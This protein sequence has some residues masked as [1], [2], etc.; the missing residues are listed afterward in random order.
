MCTSERTASTSNPI[1]AIWASRLGRVCSR[2]TYKPFASRCRAFAWRIAYVR[3]DFIVPGRPDTSTTWPTGKPPPR[4]SS[5]PSM[6]VGI[7]F[8]PMELPPASFGQR[9]ATRPSEPVEFPVK[10][11]IEP[12]PEH[13]GQGEPPNAVDR[14]ALVVAHRAHAAVRAEVPDLRMDRVRV[15]REHRVRRR[16]E[17]AFVDRFGVRFARLFRVL[18]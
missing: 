17:P 6:N 7:F 12:E 5:R 14:V 16:E 11:G 4:T 13:L 1:A 10:I 8:V 18:G 15:S 9:D 2:E 3:V